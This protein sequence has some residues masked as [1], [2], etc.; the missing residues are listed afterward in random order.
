[1]RLLIGI[2]GAIATAL[3][4][5]SVCGIAQAGA[6]LDNWQFDEGSDG[7]VTASLYATN[8]LITGG[9]AL[10]YS[11]V[12]TIACRKD[13]EPRWSEWLY[14]N[15]AVSA[16]GTI[17]MSV[18]ADQGKKV[19]ESWSVGTRGR[20]LVRDGADGVKRLVSANRLRLSWRFGLLAG[21]GEADFDLAGVNEAVGQ[22]AG[23]CNTE[24]P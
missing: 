11:P 7:L 3:L 8:K 12:L 1:M 16:R 14:V 15:D 24:L 9:G 17:T 23:T 21:R 22:I 18:T 13:G 19:S 2:G 6:A 20:M 5:A 10:S 4:L